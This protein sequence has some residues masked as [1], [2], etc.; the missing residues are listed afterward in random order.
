MNK[1][2]R[3]LHYPHLTKNIIIQVENDI[4][5]EYLHFT[6]KPLSHRVIYF[7]GLTK[8]NSHEDGS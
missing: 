7:I 4:F 8:L 6:S 5:V 3:I 1:D 2:Y